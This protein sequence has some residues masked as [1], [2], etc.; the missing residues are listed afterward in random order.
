MQGQNTL[1]YLKPREGSHH[2]PTQESHMQGPCA[3][4]S[5]GQQSRVRSAAGRPQQPK[6]DIS[7]VGSTGSQG[8]ATVSWRET[9][10]QHR[11]R[12]WLLAEIP[13]LLGA[14]DCIS[15]YYVQSKSSFL[16]LQGLQNSG[17]ESQE[18]ADKQECNSPAP[19]AGAQQGEQ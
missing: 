14:D 15:S 11:V 1:P 9:H 3:P 5:P 13:S 12:E 16:G 19:C 6:D 8:I 4:D 17:R 2:S 7:Q 10:R 18:I